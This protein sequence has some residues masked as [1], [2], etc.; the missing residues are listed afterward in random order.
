[1]SANKPTPQIVYPCWEQE[2]GEFTTARD[3]QSYN[4]IINWLWGRP[5]RALWIYR[6]DFND[7]L[8]MCDKVNIWTPTEPPEKLRLLHLLGA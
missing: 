6:T 1:M 7:W 5:D 4:N 2:H 8:M 3:F